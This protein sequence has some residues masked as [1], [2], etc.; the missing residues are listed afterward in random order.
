MTLLEQ[1]TLRQTSGGFVM[2]TL[3]ALT[4]V[5]TCSVGLADELP[6]NT[7]EIE[8][9]TVEQAETLVGRNQWSLYLD[10]L[11]TLSPDVA[12][13]LAQVKGQI[14]LNG[15]TTLSKETAEQLAAPP[16]EKHRS[17]SLSLNG[18]STLSPAVAE[19]LVKI[20]GQLSLRGLKSVESDVAT[21]LIAHESFAKGD[22]CERRLKSAARGGRKVQRW[23]LVESTLG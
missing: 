11:I 6:S 14:S 15:L 20:K 12:K 19:E 16:Q 22:F 3:L 2:R 18:L 7:R 9:L 5:L 4:L 10:G 8:T 23:G 17:R 13:I 1:G 21:I